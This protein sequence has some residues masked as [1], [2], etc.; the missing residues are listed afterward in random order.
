VSWDRSASRGALCPLC[1]PLAWRART[2]AGGAS[3][4]VSL[5]RP[6]IRGSVRAGQ[7]T[8]LVT[9][10]VRAPSL[11]LVPSFPCLSVGGVCAGSV[12]LILLAAS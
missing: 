3:S 2:R 1:R 10:S 12:L 11:P 9:P 6:P 4:L 5:V 8:D 7:G